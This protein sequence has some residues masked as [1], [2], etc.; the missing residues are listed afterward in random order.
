[1][2]PLVKSSPHFNMNNKGI[3]K[4]LKTQKRPMIAKATPS[5]G[6][7]CKSGYCFWFQDMWQAIVI[8]TVFWL[9]KSRM[10]TNRLKQKMQIWVHVIIA[11]WNSTKMANTHSRKRECLQTWCH[12]TWMP[13]WN[14]PCIYHLVQKLTPNGSRLS[15]EQ[16]KLLEGNW[17]P[18]KILV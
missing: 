10:Q 6:P 11:I 5:W 4:F 8:E 18:Y 16:L 2:Q 13:T 17:V 1:M 9:H 12:K 3:L 7:G 14:Q 15:N